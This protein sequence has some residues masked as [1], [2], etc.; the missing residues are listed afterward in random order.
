MIP[1]L[2]L[3]LIFGIKEQRKIASDQTFSYRGKTYLLHTDEDLRYRTVEVCSNE[4]G[5]ER[6]LVF[7]REYKASVVQSS[8]QKMLKNAA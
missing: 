5:A 4:I 3:D 8:T 7:G 2:D 1:E 6:F